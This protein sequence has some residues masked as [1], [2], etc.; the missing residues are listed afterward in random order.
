MY[1]CSIFAYPDICLGV[2]SKRMWLLVLCKTEPVKRYPTE[3]QNLTKETVFQL[4]PSYMEDCFSVYCLNALCIK[5]IYFSLLF[6]LLHVSFTKEL[7][8]TGCFKILE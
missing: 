2:F 8:V 7:I 5:I 1:T 4:N 6:Y 3:K